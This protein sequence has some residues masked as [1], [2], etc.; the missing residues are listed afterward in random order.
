MP[1]I[2]ARWVRSR[3]KV[4]DGAHAEA[5][6]LE[7]FLPPGNPDPESATMKV[8]YRYVFEREGGAAVGAA[9]AEE[10]AE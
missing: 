6:T 9:E 4:V 10:E 1:Y 8:K 7:Y 3:F 2:S 5:L